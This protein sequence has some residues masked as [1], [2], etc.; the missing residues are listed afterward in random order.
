MTKTPIEY[1]PQGEKTDPGAYYHL[2]DMDA[3][4]TLGNGGWLST[5]R[6]GDTYYKL[7]MPNS[8]EYYGGPVFDALLAKRPSVRAVKVKE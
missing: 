6:N 4:D 7:W 3:R 1:L 8:N 5:R 2:R